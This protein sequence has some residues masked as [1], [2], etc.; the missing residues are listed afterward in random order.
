LTWIRCL[1]KPEAFATPTKCL[2]YRAIQGIKAAG[3][4]TEA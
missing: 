4:E 2:G 1:S 3:R